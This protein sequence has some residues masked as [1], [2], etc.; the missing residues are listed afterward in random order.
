VK[1][2]R[3]VIFFIVLF[4][5][6]RF[7]FI[8][9]KINCLAI[10]NAIESGVCE[11]INQRF[12]HKSLFFTDFENDQIWDELLATEEYSQVYQYQEIKKNLLG[13][14]DLTLLTKL[15]DYRIIIG[16]ERYLLNQNNKLKN[17][18]ERLDLPS[19]EFMG[20]ELIENQGYLDERYHHKFLALSQALQ[21]Y[22]VKTTKIIWQSNQEIR[23]NV[24]HLEIILDDLK[25][26]DHQIKRLSLVLNKEELKETLQTKKLLDMRFN[27]P[28][29]KDF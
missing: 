14:A 28:V 20:G 9:K 4:V 25:S 18:Q 1:I 24:G 26:F 13:T 3:F 29:L 11:K 23:L 8:F 16:Q 17:D 19:I 15:P 12:R 22:Q 21:K 10:S 5:F 27:L 2:L 6:L 7:I